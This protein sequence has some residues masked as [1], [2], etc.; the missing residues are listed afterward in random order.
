MIHG[1]TS[2]IIHR[3]CL[4]VVFLAGKSYTA[5]SG[6]RLMQ[7]GVVITRGRAFKASRADVD[8]SLVSRL[9][10]ASGWGL[11]RQRQVRLVLVDLIGFI[12]IDRLMKLVYS[13][14]FV[15]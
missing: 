4:S 5:S 2:N 8:G 6:R 15:L 13:A 1:L 3:L 11:V 9:P 12:V 14:I 10:V 7:S